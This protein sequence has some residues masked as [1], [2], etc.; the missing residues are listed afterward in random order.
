MKNW[1]GPS[2]QVLAFGSVRCTMHIW[3]C[4]SASCKPL[5]W[6]RILLGD[7]WTQ[8][9]LHWS[10]LHPEKVHHQWP[11]PTFSPCLSGLQPSRITASLFA[12]VCINYGSIWHILQNLRHFYGSVP[13]PNSGCALFFPPFSLPIFSCTTPYFVD[14]LFCSPDLAFLF[15]FHQSIPSFYVNSSCFSSLFFFFSSPKAMLRW[16]LWCGTAPRTEASATTVIG[17]Y[18][19]INQQVALKLCKSR[20]ISS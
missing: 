6:V 15:L 18:T 11:T 19:V 1:I 3:V 8:C 16:S 10:V 17:W 5:C 9:L 13:I 12:Y 20:H 14:F 4:I 7:L 2:A